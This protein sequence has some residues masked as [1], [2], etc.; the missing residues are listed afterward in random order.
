MLAA[1]VPYAGFCI[2][3]K[4]VV[5]KIFTTRAPGAQAATCSPADVVR[6][7]ESPESPGAIGFVA[8][9]NTLPVRSPAAA[10]AACAAPYGVARTTTSAS[11]TASP[12]E[13]APIIA[14]FMVG[15]PHDRSSVVG[16][17]AADPPAKREPP[18]P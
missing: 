6:P 7:M 10:N 16:G 13:P 2:L 8:S 15:P 12:T 1:C 9:S 11:R 5:L 18:Q 4:P 14:I 3:L 17:P